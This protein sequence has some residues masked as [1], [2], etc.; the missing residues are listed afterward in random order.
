MNYYYIFTNIFR[1]QRDN[2][3]GK[4]F[5]CI[6]LTE[7]QSSPPERTLNAEPELSLSIAEYRSKSKRVPHR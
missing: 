7:A 2:R 6:V 5:S 1:G 3:E 4:M